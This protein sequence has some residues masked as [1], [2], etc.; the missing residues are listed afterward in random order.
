VL[1]CNFL[2]MTVDGTLF[3]RME[4]VD[5]RSC[6][7]VNFNDLQITK[8]EPGRIKTSNFIYTFPASL[9]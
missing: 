8:Y 6:W 4:V 5:L 2:L 9:R 7:K 3:F 1:Y